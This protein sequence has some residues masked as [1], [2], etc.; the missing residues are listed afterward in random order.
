MTPR[1]RSIL[2][3]TCGLGLLGAVADRIVASPALLQ[4]RDFLE[5]WAA[6][7]LNAFGENPYDAEKLL[8]L[9]RRA[10]PS[11]DEAVMMWNPPWSLALYMPVGLLPPR[12]AA[13][14]WVAVQLL[15]AIVAAAMLWHTYGGPVRRRG[16]AI[17]IALVFAPIVWTAAFGQ[18]TGF[19]VLGL[20]GFAYFR[21]FDR[22]VLAGAFAA[23][24]ALKPHL[25]AVFGVLLVL[26]AVNRRGR[27]ALASGAAVLAAGIAIALFANPNVCSQYRQAVMHEHSGAIPLH[28]WV[29]PVPSYWLRVFA[30]LNFGLG[31][32]VQ[33]VP[34][35]A[36]CLA[37]GAYRFYR[38][39]QWNWT[40]E[41]PCVVWVS[42]LATP[43]GG[44]I[45]DLAVLLV[46]AIA[47][48]ARLR[49]IALGL[50]ALGQLGITAISLSWVYT[51]P[52]F[53]W[54]APA[55]LALCV[56]GQKTGEA[57]PLP[58]LGADSLQSER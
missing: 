13:L 28:A 4:P 41:L 12:W 17:G 30:T 20:A 39:T 18:A 44:W 45:F 32:W 6:G 10:D 47:V 56:L 50:F 36:A 42:V 43:Y 24:T 38:G 49:P 15:A 53:F 33:F 51:L 9:Q 1:I 7:R 11:R 3:L 34:C 35:Q 8:E 46:P 37:Y 22:P 57:H 25:L 16:A 54:I 31:F 55:I 48:A 27:I 14:V 52:E 58:R 26:D 21:Q 40:A 5:Y 19:V 2:V 29:L 23:L